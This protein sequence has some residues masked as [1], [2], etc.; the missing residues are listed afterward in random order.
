MI[1][2]VALALAGPLKDGVDAYDRGEYSEAIAVWSAVEHPSGVVLYNMGNAWYR[3][4]DAPRAIAYYRA[5][6]RSRPRDTDLA[7]SLAIARE[8]LDD[9][10][11]PVDP[12]RI[13]QAFITS[14]E[15]GV[16]GLLG[17][18]G[19]SALAVWA[20]RREQ[21]IWGP[22]LVWAIGVFVLVV[23]LFGV[24][25]AQQ[26]PVA[27]V[28]DTPAAVRDAAMPGASE[29]FRLPPGTEVRIAR[30]LGGFL[31]IETGDGR[32]GWVPTGAVLATGIPDPTSQEP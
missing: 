12:P 2:L 18:A 24:R 1:W 3:E 28:V 29:R 6:A 4:G 25:A 5:S 30:R 26:H 16:L 8:Q 7:H 10:P 22:G 31:L 11:P 9:T 23:A 20:R 14:G 21:S 13:W 27:V 32:R 15:L 17:I 19:G